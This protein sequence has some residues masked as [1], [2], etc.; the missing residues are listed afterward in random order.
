VV[1]R[2]GRL[3]TARINRHQ[4]NGAEIVSWEKEIICDLLKDNGTSSALS[5]EHLPILKK[6]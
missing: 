2:Y 4:N 5:D 3:S 6:F 1:E